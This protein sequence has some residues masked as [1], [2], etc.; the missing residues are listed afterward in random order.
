MSQTYKVGRVHTT[1]HTDEDDITHVKYH[2]T[3]VVRFNS[4]YIR[5]CKGGWQTAT[6]KSRM[7]Q[8]S[9]Q[10]NLGYLV[11]QED[12]DWF[13]SYGWSNKR[14]CHKRTVPFDTDVIT[15]QR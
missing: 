13:V 15:I 10:F 4:Q 2:S 12:F 14:M 7:N 6:T 11:Y 8:A 3:D 9:N 5:L 1:V